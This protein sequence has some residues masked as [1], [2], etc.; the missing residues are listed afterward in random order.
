[1]VAFVIAVVGDHVNAGKLLLK[2][3]VQ[4]KMFPTMIAASSCTNSSQVPLALHPLSV[5]KACS[6]K[7]LP[8]NGA[9]PPV[10]GFIA[11]GV[12]QVLV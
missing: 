6:G 4:L 5:V 10:I 12:K 3:I 1:M 8:V 7:K 11:V 2:V 9:E